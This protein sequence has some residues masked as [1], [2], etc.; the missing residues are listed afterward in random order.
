M[1][2]ERVEVS[3]VE[4]EVSPRKQGSHL[5]R[6]VSMVE[7]AIRNRKTGT[8]ALSFKNGGL[9]HPSKW[10]QRPPENGQGKKT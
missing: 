1:S 2:V 6:A 7:W 3:K 5:D 8:L 9:T 10:S 4:Y